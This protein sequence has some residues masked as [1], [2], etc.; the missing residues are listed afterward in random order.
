[1]LKRIIV[2][3]V[4]FLILIGISLVMVLE[5]RPEKMLNKD[6]IVIPDISLE[7]SYIELNRENVFYP[8]GKDVLEISAVF[9]PKFF[10]LEAILVPKPS[11]GFAIWRFLFVIDVKK[12]S[13]QS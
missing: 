12:S 9:V 1:M 8:E 7:Q 4:S 3:L 10:I 13:Q 2:I 6:N 5:F 11:P